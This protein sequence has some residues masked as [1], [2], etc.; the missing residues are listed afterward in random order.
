MEAHAVRDPT[1][2]ERMIVLAEAGRATMLD[3]L[4]LFAVSPVI[5]PS[6]TQVTDNLSQLQPVLFDVKGS[7]M[8]AVFTHADQIADFGDLAAF[9]LTIDGR[10]LLVSIPPGAG[11]VVNP[12]RS[13]GFELTPDGL[14]AFLGRLGGRN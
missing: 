4:E 1:E 3:V 14:G 12:S 9:A 7:S 13:I 5:V 2:L 6:G 8:L 10:S 11:V